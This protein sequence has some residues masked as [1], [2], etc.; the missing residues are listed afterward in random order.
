MVESPHRNGPP[1]LYTW[2]GAAGNDTQEATQK[3]GL[4]FSAGS[5]S[6]G[7]TVARGLFL[8]NLVGAGAGGRQAHRRV[9]GWRCSVD[10][11]RAA[12]PR[13]PGALA[14]N[15]TNL[16]RRPLSGLRTQFLGCDAAAAQLTE[17]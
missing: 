13:T 17:F 2:V 16:P 9:L 10:M 15:R 11:R 14:S 1:W 7:N 8:S 5:S 12:R 6:C 3:K 4:F